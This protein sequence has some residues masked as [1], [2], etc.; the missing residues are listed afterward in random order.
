M[1]PIQYSAK[2][3]LSFL[4][5]FSLISFTFDDWSLEKDDAGIKVYTR[6]VDGSDLKEYRAET[7]VY[8]SVDD[9]TTLLKQPS[10]SSSWMEGCSSSKLLKQL[11]DNEF[12]GYYYNPAPWPVKDRDSISKMKF[13]KQSNGSVKVIIEG[14][15][16]Y[17]P[18][19][20]GV[21]RVPYLKGFWELIP[22]DNDKT[23][24]IQ[25]VHASPGGSIPSWL[26]NSSVVDIPFKTFINLKQITK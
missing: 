7:I 11:K 24:I 1:Y 17:I 22:Q 14:L 3:M 26:A 6:I 19:K 4:I 16:D 23:K 12:I 25:Q 18:E 13:E 2:I 20:S 21:V 10:L 5:V 9:I 15:P 8:A